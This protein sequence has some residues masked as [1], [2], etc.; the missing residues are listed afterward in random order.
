[1]ITATATAC[2]PGRFCPDHATDPALL[3]L[4]AAAVIGITL[5]AIAAVLLVCVFDQAG[6]RIHRHLTRHRRAARHYAAAISR[7]RTG[8]TRLPNGLCGYCYVHWPCPLLCRLA[9][10]PCGPDCS[11]WH[12]PLPEPIPA[13]PH[14]DVMASAVEDWWRDTDPT[15]D[16]ATGPDI[17]AHVEMYL[18]SS[19]YHITPNP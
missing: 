14:R 13:R 15:E 5:F 11:D 9:G 1:M 7:V 2:E 16:R 18:T 12:A 3:A 17:A 8:H 4:M 19:G 10:P 6:R